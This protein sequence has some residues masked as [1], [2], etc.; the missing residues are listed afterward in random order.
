MGTTI[1]DGQM[2]FIQ[3]VLCDER[4]IE[5]DRSEEGEPLAYLHGGGQIISG[6]EEALEG[7]EFG[8]RV[9]VEIQPD[10]G[11]GEHDPSR[12]MTV[13]REQFDFEPEVG[14]VVRA[15]APGR[16]AHPFTIVDVDEATVTLDGNHPLAGR[17]LSFEVRVESIREATAEEILE[18]EQEMN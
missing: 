8:A 3:Y 5:V 4:G 13:A 14:G 6:L 11:Y 17:A 16:Q 12:V 9:R 7:Y 18:A 15:E 10:E 2:V 1:H